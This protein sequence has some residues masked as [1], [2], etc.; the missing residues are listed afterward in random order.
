MPQTR[1]EL[2]SQLTKARAELAESQTRVAQLEGLLSEDQPAPDSLPDIQGYERS[3]GKL[4]EG[5]QI[6]SFDW[7][8]LY[9]NDAA[10][11]NLNLT[12]D[13]IVGHT[14]MGLHPGIVNTELFAVMQRCMTERTAQDAEFEF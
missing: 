8:Y 4:L 14:V 5:C 12:V 9:C 6:I 11:R 3:F 10:A 13:N 2:L 7:R 1:Q